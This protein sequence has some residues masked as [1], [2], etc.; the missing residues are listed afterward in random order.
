MPDKL[1][2]IS[3]L[4][5]GTEEK[6]ILHDIDLSV[7]A[8]ETHVLMGPN[9]AGK[10]TLGRVIMGDPSYEVSS[11][12]VLFEGADITD[13]S[14]DK[15]SLAGIFL[16]YQA[17][18]EVPG[19]PLYSFLRTICQMRPE[20][21]MNARTFRERVGEI[22]EQLDLDE[23]FLTRELNVGFSGGEKKK[24]EM[25]QLLL[26]RPKLAIL[27]ETDSGLDVDALAIVSRGISVYL[28]SCNG[29]LLMITHNT[30]ILERL[31]VDHTHVIVRGHMVAEGP[32][33][34]IEQIDREGFER[35]ETLLRAKEDSLPGG[36]E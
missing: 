30:R 17:P 6:P 11:G 22:A 29:S 33:Q 10:S 8:G 34:L 27:D 32:G 16:S 15:R 14:P 24:L 23:S 2:T 36:D 19:V 3:G 28:T 35:Y 4:S 12:S 21:K 18:V 26:L 9:G 5:A 20:L 1:L 7:G 13:L 25:L 31:D